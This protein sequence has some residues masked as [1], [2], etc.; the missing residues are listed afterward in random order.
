MQN[1]N[2]PVNPPSQDPPLNWRRQDIE[3]RLG[4]TGGRFTTTNNLL[5]AIF[6]LLTTALFF[7]VVIWAQQRPG[8]RW[9]GDMF[10]ERGPCQFVTMFLFFWALGILLIKTQKLRLQRRALAVNA[11]PV[12]GDFQLNTTTARST[13]DRIHGLADATGHF[14]L[15]NRIERALSNLKNIGQISD[16]SSILQTQAAYDEEQI[17][18]SYGLVQGF[19]W[20]IP[21]LGF[22][23]T[24]LGLSQA[25][26]FFGETLKS[27]GD[28]A[29]IRESL[30]S[31]T[32][33]LATAFETTLVALVCALVLQLLVTYLQT[34]ESE[35]LDSCNDF[36]HANVV[37]RLRLTQLS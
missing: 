23:G 24:V 27:D 14:L 28:M 7:A 8:L 26:G 2:L 3:N 19:I 31:V 4:F 11:V 17:N 12:Q 5:T 34:K 32:A 21:V 35:F 18:S 10:L 36:C 29:G 33:G 16:V 25:I 1:Q 22:I 20:A 6:G 9:F 13:L 15:L 37:S 30:Q